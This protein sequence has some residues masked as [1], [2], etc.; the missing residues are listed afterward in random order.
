MM[1]FVCS[2]CF[3]DA[4]LR[5]FVEGEAVEDECDFCGEKADHAIAAPID[6]V[7][8]HIDE[9]I[10][11]DYDDAANCLSYETAEGGWLGKTWDTWDLLA[12]EIGL[13]L[14]RDAGQNLFDAIREELGDYTWCE[15]NPYGLNYEQR[16][17][18]SWERFCRVVKHERRFFSR[19]MA[20]IQNMMRF[21]LP[22]RHCSRYLI[23]RKR[24]DCSFLCQVKRRCFGP[25][26]NHRVRT[27]RQW[28][29]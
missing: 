1:K 8:R 15:R 23:A 25:D 26:V 21:C 3:G 12:D 27:T 2:E 9:C 11:E 5:E 18:Y 24:S 13:D 6:E 17:R 10:R 19:N 4:A 7:G 14:S 20:P 29:S 28:K 22:A 16:G